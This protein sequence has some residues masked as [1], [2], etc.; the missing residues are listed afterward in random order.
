DQLIKEIESGTVKIKELATQAINSSQVGS[1]IMVDTC[2]YVSPLLSQSCH[3]C[4]CNNISEF[5]NDTP[6][7]STS[8][9]VAGG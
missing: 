7:A 2:N 6:K 8:V 9:L 1:T 4:G 5:S 3:N